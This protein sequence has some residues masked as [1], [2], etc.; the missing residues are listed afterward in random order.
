MTASWT[1]REPGDE[2][3]KRFRN[4]TYG[5]V[6]RALRKAE[7]VLRKLAPDEQAAERAQV[8]SLRHAWAQQVLGETGAL[9]SGAMRIVTTLT[10][11]ERLGISPTPTGLDG[12]G[13]VIEVWLT[14]RKRL[15]LVERWALPAMLMPW[16]PETGVPWVDPELV[17]QIYAVLIR[18]YFRAI[19]RKRVGQRWRT[20]REPAGWPILTQ[21]VIPALYDYLRPYYP[22]RPYR[23][24]R[25][26]RSDS[27]FP[28]ALRQDITDLIKFECPHLAEALTTE[29]VT[30]SIQRYLRRAPRDRRMG[31]ALFKPTLPSPEVPPDGKVPRK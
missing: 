6:D 28:A 12:P 29:R 9:V 7:G 17:S 15:Y 21:R 27:H 18:T 30:A 20:E 1:D 10:D 23:H 5:A 19:L 14:V 3:S 26:S 8:R 31:I 24:H 25:Q 2:I 13:L 11:P 16:R 22:A 4:K